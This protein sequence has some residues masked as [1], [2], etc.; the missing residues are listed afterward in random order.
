MPV[1]KPALSFYDRRRHRIMVAVS[2]VWGVVYL[3]LLSQA[4]R[5]KFVALNAFILS[6][7]MGFFASFALLIFSGDFGPGARKWCR[8]LAWLLLIAG[9]IAFAVNESIHPLPPPEAVGF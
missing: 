6:G 4:L 3:K 2:V 5:S 9:G 7:E 8:R 1:E